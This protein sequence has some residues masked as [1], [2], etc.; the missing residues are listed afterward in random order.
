M[1]PAIIIVSISILLAGSAG[2]LWSFQRQ[3]TQ[4]VEVP[5]KPASISLRLN[6]PYD[7]THA[8]EMVAAR[9]GLFE[10]AGVHL[11]L[12]P[13]GPDADPIAGVVSGAD[14]FGVARGDTFLV[15]RSKGAPIVAF[16][17]AYLES[18]VAFFALEKSGIHTPQDFVGKR[19]VRQ[20]GQ[21]SA[22]I[23]DAVLANLNISRGLIRE[24]STGV[25]INQLINGD[26]DVRPGHIGKESYLLQQKGIPYN[27]IH[28]SDYGI[29]VPGTVYFTS[30]KIIH[31][32]PSL[33]QKVLD[34]IIA[35]WKSTYA[36]YSKS[37][38]LIT[39]FDER[40]LTPDRVLFELKAQRDSVL[41]LGRRF[42]EYDD[43]QWKLLGDI[44]INERLI[45]DA[46]SIDLSKAVTYEFLREAY[47]KPI[48]FGN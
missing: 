42:T 8:G 12:K 10:R 3:P 14:T 2:V 27:I 40:T 47:R 6:G 26:V 17:A 23:Y 39:A 25:D 5:A 13:G 45:H 41:P 29:H 16:A 37:V 38:P 30:E 9:S 19:V 48:S 33:V 15:A 46:D 7:P 34:A 18:A 1:R 21:N 35:G 20:A 43:M 11:E 31:G 28:P 32:H 44:L 22:T 4:A 36:D 24:I